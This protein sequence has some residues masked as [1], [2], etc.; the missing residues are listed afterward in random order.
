MP[1]SFNYQEFI[2][3]KRKHLENLIRQYEAAYNQL[4]T[5]LDET[6]KVSIRAKIHD[7][8][9]E[10]QKEI[11]EIEE[12]EEKV[13]F[14]SSNDNDSKKNIE[15]PSDPLD[16]PPSPSPPSMAEKVI[17]FWQSQFSLRRVV[18]MPIITIVV[19]ILRLSGLLQPLELAAFDQMMRLRPGDDNPDNR[20]LI[21][22]I[23]QDDIDKNRAGNKNPKASLP[24]STY[25]KLFEKLEKYEPRTIGLDI[26]RPFTVMPEHKK[27]T[28]ILGKDNFFAICKILSLSPDSNE[29]TSN[30]APPPEI[31]DKSRLGFSDF[32]SDR[33]YVVRRHLLKV[34]K[35]PSYEENK[36]PTIHSFSLQITLH[37][38]NKE[39]EIG[40][41]KNCQ[42]Y[43]NVDYK[44]GKICNVSFKPIEAF[45]GGYRL[46]QLGGDQVLLNY[47]SLPYGQKQR[48]PREIAYKINLNDI[49]NDRVKVPV[50][51]LKDRIILIGIHN[52]E[53][54]WLTPYGDRMPGVW[55]H[56]QMV[57][58]ILSA[59]LD[60]RS[61]LQ[62]MP[63][64][65]DCFWIAIWSL[66]G[67]IT[68]KFRRWSSLIIAQGVACGIL[69]LICFLLFIADV[70][71]PF[72]PPVIAFVGTSVIIFFYPKPSRDLD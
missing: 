12:L 15:T 11:S 2:Q 60:G 27:L 66:L 70:W 69:C 29:D 19:I 8:E 49:L 34:E 41:L 52:D 20:L 38:L 36:C 22:E 1:S 6:V 42:N 10:I 7:Y 58:Q 4:D 63:W 59:V 31:K 30:V 28:Q 71:L 62:V 3:A 17:D 53:D 23:N 37:Y 18:I 21:V 16:A 67:G 64:W 25:E 14:S 65:G 26:Y 47:R 45:M 54:S 13:K 50:E 32:D 56:A 43:K 72:V 39:L 57:S 55:I 44:D 68:W 24:D 46:D 51:K 5:T 61:L 35:T 33:D 40:N 9:K 48:S